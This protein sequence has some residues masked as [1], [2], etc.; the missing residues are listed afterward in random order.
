MPGNEEG[1][2]W[3][4][5]P[6]TAHRQDQGTKQFGRWWACQAQRW[7]YRPRADWLRLGIVVPR[8]DPA[9]MAWHEFVQLHGSEEAA[10]GALVLRTL[11]DAA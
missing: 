3:Q 8:T 10:L 7:P 11:D 9:V 6:S 2:P 1:R 4:G 5:G